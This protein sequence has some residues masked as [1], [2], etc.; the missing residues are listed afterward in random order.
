MINMLKVLMKKMWATCKQ[1]GNISRE[2]ETQS[3]DQKEM[4][5]KSKNV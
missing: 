4:L 1:T 3:E 2:L 5:K